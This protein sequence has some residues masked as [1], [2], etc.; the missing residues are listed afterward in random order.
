MENGISIYL[1]LDNTIEEN[2]QLIKT[3]H[4]YGIKRI[5]T[6]L[7]IPETNVNLLQ[8]QL[9]IVLKTANQYGMEVISDVSPNTLSLLN[10]DKLD[11]DKL[12]EMGISTIRLDFG[13]S[14]KD[15]AALSKLIK[16]QFNASTL[17]KEFL[18]ELKFYHTD[19][20]CIDA[21]H[22]FYPREGTGLDEAFLLEKN[23]LLHAYNVKTAAFVPSYNRAR[24]P[25]KKGLSTLEIHRYKPLSMAINHLSLLK[26]DS[27][28]IGDSLPTKEE[29][30]TLSALT[31]DYVTIRAKCLTQNQFIKD[32]LAKNV[33]TTRQDAALMAIRTQESRLLCKNEKIY[34]EYI[35]NR[36][37][38]M[39]TM[40]NIN[41][42]RY[43]GELQIILKEQ[44]QYKAVNIIGKILDSDM[45]LLKYLKPGSKFKIE[46]M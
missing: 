38:G 39:I 45:I 29:M 28:F 7:H 34:P 20:N 42:G 10:L 23:T 37:V 44:K 4:K 27:V 5:F 18:D 16:I 15:I 19:F 17:T 8:A 24:S 43:M 6:S 41:S 1:G 22:N 46:L 2:L 40:D 9:Q 32:L 14:E 11:T 12:Q 3:A 36:D 35:S 13:Y 31:K 26:V 33:F 30:K 25:L 21:L